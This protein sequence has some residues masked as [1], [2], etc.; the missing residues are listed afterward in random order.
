MRTSAM[1]C[2]LM[3]PLNFVTDAEAFQFL[4]KIGDGVEWVCVTNQLFFPYGIG[5]LRALCNLG[6]KIFLDI[7]L[8]DTPLGMASSL[9]SLRDQAIDL[10]SVQLIQGLPALKFSQL[11]LKQALPDAQLVA[12]TILYHLHRND[13]LHQNFTDLSKRLIQY[14][15][16]LALA[17]KIYYVLCTACEFPYLLK[18]FGTNF[19]YIIYGSDVNGTPAPYPFFNLAKMGAK[20]L[21]LGEKCLTH[22]NPREYIAHV[23]REITPAFANL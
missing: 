8:S 19:T 16:R 10:I 23:R 12:S 3:V 6:Y 18:Q 7:R 5:L 14:Y 13:T 20:I 4:N 17:A 22:A 21:M 15:F 1:S 11:A 2:E 9:L